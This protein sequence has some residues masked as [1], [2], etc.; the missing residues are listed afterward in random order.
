MAAERAITAKRGPPGYGGEVAENAV[1][2]RN[3]CARKQRRLN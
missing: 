1:K 2:S 3:E